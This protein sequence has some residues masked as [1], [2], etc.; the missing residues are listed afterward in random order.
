MDAV[1]RNDVEYNLNCLLILDKT[2]MEK[3][4]HYFNWEIVWDVILDQS[5]GYV[6]AK[7]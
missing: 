4:S 7:V 2:E 6:A 5:V 3:P 1:Q